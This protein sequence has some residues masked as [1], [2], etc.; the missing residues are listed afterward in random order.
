MTDQTAAGAEA[1]ASTST[2]DPDA[3]RYAAAFA[4]EG[5]TQAD[6]QPAAEPEAK[7]EPQAEKPPLPPEELAKRHE[8]VKAA[9][10][11][12]R[13]QRKELSRQIEELRTQRAQP[14]PAQQPQPEPQA[15][16]RPDPET[17]PLAYLKYVEA[18]I[19]AGDQQAA[20]QE[21]QRQQAE[22]QSREVQTVVNRMVE[23]ESDFALDNPDYYEAANFLRAERA[24]EYT[25]LGYSPQQAEQLVAQEALRVAADL[26]NQ[27][28]D[29]ASAFYELAKARGFRGASPAPTPTPAETKPSDALARVKAGQAAAQTLSGS[30]GGST[31][32][33]LDVGH[34]N[35]LKGAAFD[36]A[37]DK[38]REA[39]R[40]AERRTGY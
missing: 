33:D 2:P 23:I 40:A 35:T 14:A 6:A 37:F 29:A 39:A 27:R 1:G 25:A 5:I 28:K 7:P 12:E 18:R 30:G 15:F 4:E 11:E 20:E 31:N 19:S 38:L 24:K 16:E 22:L 13:R 34:I 9:L 36:A 8:D 26:L 17:D 21:Q 10:R 3:E 32:K